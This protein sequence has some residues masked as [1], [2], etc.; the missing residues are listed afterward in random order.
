M[1]KNSARKLILWE[2]LR[3]LLNV[4]TIVLSEKDFSVRQKF[5]ER[6]LKR[7]FYVLVKELK[8]FDHEFFF[9]QF[10]MTPDSTKT[11]KQI[12]KMLVDYFV[13]D[14]GKVKWQSETIQCTLHNSYKVFVCHGPISVLKIP[15]F[16][17][18]FL[19]ILLVQMNY[20]VS[21]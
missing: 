3:L 17:R 1:A 20:L 16:H 19:S 10:H 13:T 5:M 8:L 7:E 15:L 21:Q 6:N 2:L 4:K 11:A 12:R 14:F 18:C 9:K